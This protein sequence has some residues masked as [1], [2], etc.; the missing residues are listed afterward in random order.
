[1]KNTVLGGVFCVS[2]MAYI[3]IPWRKI[4]IKEKRKT[5]LMFFHG[6][7]DCKIKETRAS[8]SY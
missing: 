6:K 7:K 5:P 2:G 8:E 1:M 3:D 4:N